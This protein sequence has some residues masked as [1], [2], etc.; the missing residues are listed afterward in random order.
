MFFV[1]LFIGGIFFVFVC[2]L[3]TMAAACVT[4]ALRLMVLSV[5][6]LMLS[7]EG[8]GLERVKADSLR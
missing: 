5:L 4:M 3:L 7:G 2:R 1:F 8:D 6:R